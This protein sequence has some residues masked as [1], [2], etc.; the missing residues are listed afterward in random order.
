M[1][2]VVMEIVVMPGMLVFMSR[3]RKSCGGLNLHLKCLAMFDSTHL[4]VSLSPVIKASS[5]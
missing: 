2:N 3:P 5:T 4:T 1:V